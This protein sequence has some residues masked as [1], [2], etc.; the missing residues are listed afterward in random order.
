MVKRLE[1]V[2]LLCFTAAICYPEYIAGIQPFGILY[3]LLYYAYL[4]GMAL[5]LLVAAKVHRK[6]IGWVALYYGS[7]ICSTYLYSGLDIPLFRYLVKSAFIM[8]VVMNFMACNL[9]QWGNFFLKL[10]AMFGEIGA[11]L[12]LIAILLVPDGL[13]H[14]T[15]TGEPGWLYGHKN[16]LLINMMLSLIASAILC[17][18]KRNRKISKRTYLFTGIVLISGYLSG[19]VTAFVGCVVLLLMMFILSFDKV[20]RQ[21]TM[22]KCMVGPLILNFSICIFRIQEIFSFFIVGVLGKDLTLSSR[23]HIWDLS[24][25][26][27]LQRPL[28]GVGCLFSMDMTRMIVLAGT[29]N[30]IIG[31]LFH[32]GLIGV[33]LWLI[34]IIVFVRRGYLYR[35]NYIMSICSVF[36]LVFMINGITENICVPTTE[37]RF[38]L[39]L[40]ICYL[41]PTYENKYSNNLSVSV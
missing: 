20:R 5:W 14:T 4:L 26:Y 34:L 22:A 1:K 30:W 13:T 32:T 9:K 21:I 3:K 33:G 17:Y 25:E 38:F 28:T 11:V 10:C 35:G 29:H 8:L 23:T 24:L 6:V 12:N 39:F 15:I 27:F 19:A 37:L 2:C 18:D 7:L 41:M 36:M 31:I 40:L 16:S